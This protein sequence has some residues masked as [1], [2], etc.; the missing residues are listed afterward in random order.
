MAW[1]VSAPAVTRL[2]S[3]FDDFNYDSVSKL[4]TAGW[5]VT[6][7]NRLSVDG[8][9]VTINNDGATVAMRYSFSNSILFD[10]VLEAR[11]SATGDPR[12]SQFVLAFERANGY[13]YRWECGGLYQEFRFVI[14]FPN[15]ETVFRRS[16]YGNYAPPDT[17]TWV[18]LKIERIGETLHFYL[19]GRWFGSYV[20]DV[21]SELAAI[22]LSPGPGSVIRYDWVKVEEQPWMLVQD[23]ALDLVASNGQTVGDLGQRYVDLASVGYR[24]SSRSAYVRFGTFGPIP[25]NRPSPRVANIWYQVIA[26]I[27]PDTGYLWSNDFTPEY[28]LEFGVNYNVSSSTPS[29]YSQVVKYSGTGKDWRWSLVQDTQRTG[30]AATLVGGVGYDFFVLTLRYDQISV[31][32]GSTIKGLARSGIRYDGQTYNDNVPDRGY[33]SVQVRE[34]VFYEEKDF[35]FAI[36]NNHQIHAEM[37]ETLH[38]RGNDS[39]QVGLFNIG[40]GQV[41]NLRVYDYESKQELAAILEKRGDVY[42]FGAKLVPPRAG[43][44]KFLLVF[45][46]MGYVKQDREEYR[47]ALNWQTGGHPMPQRFTVKLPVGYYLTRFEGSSFDMSNEG[48]RIVVAFAGVSVP[49]SGFSWSLS[50]KSLSASTDTTTV[51]GSDSI[52]RNVGIIVGAT[53]A[54]CV[55]LVGAIAL[56]RRR[57]YVQEALLNVGADYTKPHL[58]PEVAEDI[59][60]VTVLPARLEELKRLGEISEETYQELKDEYQ[61]RAK[62]E[63]FRD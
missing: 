34:T 63:T 38:T 62:K 44:L 60:K 8:R 4:K 14:L 61:R 18:T 5:V 58:K 13:L 26:D 17:G 23:P 53:L 35:T 22:Q 51:A 16:L 39:S 2:F 25:S 42:Y 20:D 9:S 28:I 31:A 37:I 7:E 12:Y 10:W 6:N 21:T 24:F 57:K 40:N 27:N 48:G 45:D 1:G 47:L 3:F 15:S 43:D 41:L 50:Y 19:N 49:G 33:P 56:K 29:I 11:M 52:Q 55:V 46:W 59:G 54:T 30:T 36:D 32:V